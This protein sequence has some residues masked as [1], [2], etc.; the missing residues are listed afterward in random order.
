MN[1]AAF[2][3][4]F[5]CVTGLTFTVI[6]FYVT[7]NYYTQHA[8]LSKTLLSGEAVEGQVVNKWVDRNGVRRRGRGIGSAYLVSYIYQTPLRTY[9]G[10][11]KVSYDFFKQVNRND[12]LPVLYGK[13]AP[14]VSNLRDANSF[15][16]TETFFSIFFVLALIPGGVCVYLLVSRNSLKGLNQR[17]AAVVMAV[18]GGILLIAYNVTKPAKAP[19]YEG[20]YTLPAT[21]IKQEVAM[22]GNGEYK[23][24]MFE[25]WVRFK[26]AG[27][28][29]GFDTD[30]R[31]DGINIYNSFN[32]GDA[33]TI[34]THQIGVADL[35]GLPAYDAMAGKIG[36]RKSGT[37]TMPL[38]L[39]WI[40]LAFAVATRNITELAKKTQVRNTTK[41]R[42]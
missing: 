8:S 35:V 21:V 26:S 4:A 13:D 1:S 9:G 33:L 2:K 37:L 12:A 23:I 17:Q 16:A 22:R 27:R 31:L 38:V 15:D 7:A 6:C 5:W 29:P 36:Y 28:R 30:E 39:A 3:H 18:A 19:V 41:K 10:I 25:T 40:S 24:P 42:K 34:H 11:S 32:V 14:W 20:G